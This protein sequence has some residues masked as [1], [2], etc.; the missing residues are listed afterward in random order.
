MSFIKKKGRAFMTRS[1]EIRKISGLSRAAFC[2]KY[3]IPIRT[4]EDWDAGRAEAPEYVMKLLERAVNED[5][6]QVAND[7]VK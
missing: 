7:E 5:F 4:V 6:P 3:N 1:E 2:R